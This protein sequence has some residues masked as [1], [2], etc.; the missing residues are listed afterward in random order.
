M[1]FHSLD[2]IVSGGDYLLPTPAAVT[3]L[4]SHMPNTGSSE[5]IEV[6]IVDDNDYEGIHSFTMDIEPLSP[7]ATTDGG[8]SFIFI[9]DNKGK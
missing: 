4:A 6:T 9:Y 3:F 1:F 8:N 5:C 2:I 7:P